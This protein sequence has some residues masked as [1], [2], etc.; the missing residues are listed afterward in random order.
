M[1]FD[2]D[3]FEQW[4]RDHKQVREEHLFAYR[5]GAERILAVA[6]D[7]PPRRA[8]VDEAIRREIE[9]GA[10]T[11]AAKNLHTIGDALLAYLVARPMAPRVVERAEPDEPDEPGHE[12]RRLAPI[13]IGILGALAL[14]I[15]VVLLVRRRE[16]RPAVARGLATLTLRDG[17]KCA[18]QGIS[19]QYEY[20]WTPGPQKMPGGVMITVVGKVNSV[21]EKAAELYALSGATTETFSQANLREIRFFAGDDANPDDVTEIEI[22]TRDGQR[23]NFPAGARYLLLGDGTRIWTSGKIERWRT[24]EVALL[25][26]APGCPAPYVSLS[27]KHHGPS[28][29]PVRLEVH[30]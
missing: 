23:H 3:G 14:V 27:D 30:P 8:H 26:Q 19:F 24:P 2:F 29:F 6:G 20:H 28:T 15:A 25:L 16:A 11:K 18:V 9:A 10:T 5:Q 12:G 13:V 4:L 22:H 21:R 1:A 7:R 17:T